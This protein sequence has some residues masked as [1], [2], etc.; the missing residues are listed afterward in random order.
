MYILIT[1]GNK[2]PDTEAVRE[3][4]LNQPNINW[5][6]GEFLAVGSGFK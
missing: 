6:I 5:P 3:L 4:V 2:Q 1:T